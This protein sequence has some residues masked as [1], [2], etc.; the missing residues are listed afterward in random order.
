MW[1]LQNLKKYF[2]AKIDLENEA[3]KRR[4]WRFLR[5]IIISKKF[6]FRLS[7]QNLTFEK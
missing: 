7:K 4:L 3:W 5:K 1:F 6:A 2:F